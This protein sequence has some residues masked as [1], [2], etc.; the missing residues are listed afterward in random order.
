ML[1]ILSF[2]IIFSLI[3]FACSAKSSGPNLK[4]G[5]WEIT[6]ETEYKGKDMFQIPVR[7]YTQCIT[8]ENVIP[9]KI[10]PEKNCKITKHKIEGN[11]VSWV[12]EC[13]TSQ[14]SVIS[15]GVATYKETTLN[16]IIK[17]QHL[18]TEI[19]QKLKGKWIGECN[20]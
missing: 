2:F 9:Q 11:K 13:K 18:G 3:L 16:G 5:K 17:M 7:T 19:I 10:D 4:E 1:K 14:G 20:K 15:N 12:V 6:V 8:K